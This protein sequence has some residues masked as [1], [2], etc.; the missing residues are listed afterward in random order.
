MAQVA[1]GK[2]E[3]SASREA[4][5]TWAE[6]ADDL[7]IDLALPHLPHGKSEISG[8]PGK[9]E[10]MHVEIFNRLEVTPDTVISV[11]YRGEPGLQGVRPHEQYT[12]TVDSLT[13][14]ELDGEKLTVRYRDPNVPAK[15]FELIPERPLEIGPQGAPLQT[16]L[17]TL[18]GLR[19]IAVDEHGSPPWRSD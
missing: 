15:T 7:G 12:T 19:L 14:L 9:G 6:I 8:T 18:N 5:A 13:A 11:W 17:A 2:S 3:I 10:P 1:Q 4:R 16:S